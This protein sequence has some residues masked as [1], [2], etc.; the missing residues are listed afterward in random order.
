MSDT[1]DNTNQ[2][3][4][5]RV[6]DYPSELREHEKALEPFVE[7]QGA[8]PGT[9]EHKNVMEMVKRDAAMFRNAGL[10]PRHVE[11]VILPKLTE[12]QAMTPEQRQ[13]RRAETLKALRGANPDNYVHNLTLVQKWSQ[14]HQRLKNFL[15]TSG[16]GND[17]E[18]LEML[19]EIARRPGG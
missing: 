9:P 19:I 2:P 6:F 14:S 5:P 10:S 7:Q 4:A 13:T 17:R 16:L 8:I 12:Y 3:T 15:E 11:N 1:D 18:I